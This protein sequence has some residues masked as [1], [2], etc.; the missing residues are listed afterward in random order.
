MSERKQDIYTREFERDGNEMKSEDAC[1]FYNWCESAL[2]H[3]LSAMWDSLGHF[4]S[5]PSQAET[6]PAF[7]SC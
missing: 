7:G 3:S 5:G 2:G 6:A 1:A 4:I